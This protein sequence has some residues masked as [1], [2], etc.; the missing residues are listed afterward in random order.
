MDER[1]VWN[2]TQKVDQE[3]DGGDDIIAEKEL[4]RKIFG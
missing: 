2:T 1:S 3:I 4:R